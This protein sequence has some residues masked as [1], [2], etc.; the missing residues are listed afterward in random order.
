MLHD[1]TYVTVANLHVTTCYYDLL[2]IDG[3][4]GLQRAHVPLFSRHGP[5]ATA[6]SKT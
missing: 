4:S 3:R 5:K 6:T 1:V 2:Q